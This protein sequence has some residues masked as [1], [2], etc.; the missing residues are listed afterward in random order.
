MLYIIDNNIEYRPRLNLLTAIGAPYNS[1]TLP[2]PANQCLLLLIQKAPEV[3]RQDE[4]INIVWRKDNMEV[5]LN[6]LYQNISI[7]RRSLRQVSGND[8]KIISTKSRQGFC[9][10][11][12]CIYQLEEKDGLIQNDS[13]E[14]TPSNQ[15]HD[16]PNENWLFK[17]FHS[18]KKHIIKNLYCYL[19]MAAFLISDQLKTYHMYSQDFY[20]DYTLSKK[21]D[22]CT[23]FYNES[24]NDKLLNTFLSKVKPWLNCKNYPFVYI[25]LNVYSPANTILACKKR[26]DTKVN[27]CINQYL[28]IGDDI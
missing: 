2:T 14:L 1:V 12:I 5:P 15:S 7:L 9:I 21:Y 6:T 8:K 16:I 23:I 19:I 28:Y 24:D 3:V 10:C 4:F 13:S 17:T 27:R 18:I 25:P 22:G 20:E 26:Y 11:G